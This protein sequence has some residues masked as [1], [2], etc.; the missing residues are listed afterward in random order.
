M[1]PPLIEPSE[2][3]ATVQPLLERQ[4]ADGLLLA[5]LLGPPLAEFIAVVCSEPEVVVVDVDVALD[6]VCVSAIKA[7][8]SKVHELAAGVA[9]LSDENACSSEDLLMLLSVSWA[10]LQQ[11]LIWLAAWVQLSLRPSRQ[12]VVSLPL[13]R[14]NRRHLLSRQHH[15]D[16]PLPQSSVLPSVA[17]VEVMVQ[18]TS[19]KSQQYRL[20]VFGSRAQAFGGSHWKVP[21]PGQT[22]EVRFEVKK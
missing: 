17:H 9:E 2:F 15:V 4:D 10:A 3:V 19:P 6:E 5:G 14:C 18:H 16:S 8:G 1:T 13:F 20:P 21:K 12:R 11:I 7:T 22:F